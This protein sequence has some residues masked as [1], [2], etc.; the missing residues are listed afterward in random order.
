MLPFVGVHLA[1]VLHDAVAHRH[2]SI[3]FLPLVLSIPLTYLFELGGATIW[4]PSILDFVVQSTVK[5]VAFADAGGVLVPIGVDGSQRTASD[6]RAAR[7]S[8]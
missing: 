4:A 7:S 3:A 6:V 2:G 1:A 5:I 8:P